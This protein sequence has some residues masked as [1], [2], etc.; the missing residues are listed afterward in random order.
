MLSPKYLKFCS[1]AILILFANSLQN[2]IYA[3]DSMPVLV[4]EDLEISVNRDDVNIVKEPNGSITIQHYSVPHIAD[5]LRD[6]PHVPVN[7]DIKFA[8]NSSVITADGKDNLSKLA[9]VIQL[10]GDKNIFEIQGHTSNLGNS[11]SKLKLSTK[12]AE[13]ITIL[14]KNS[15]AIENRLDFLGMAD[16][17]PITTNSTND[18]QA[19]TERISIINRGGA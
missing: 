4:L 11:N 2:L 14:L 3:D 15:H 16:K 18:G 6:N 19:I 5:V 10:I 7:F 8:K 12:R 13:A 9:A 1:F 17:S